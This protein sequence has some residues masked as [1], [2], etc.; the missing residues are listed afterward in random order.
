MIIKEL[1]KNN[2]KQLEQIPE[3][4][5]KYSSC[6]NCGEVEQNQQFNCEKCGAVLESHYININMDNIKNKRKR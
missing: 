1:N 3:G 5:V 6:P 4:Q 2:L